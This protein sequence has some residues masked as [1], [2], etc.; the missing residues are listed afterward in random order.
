MQLRKAKPTDQEAIVALLKCSL[1]ETL[2]PKSVKLW[3]WKHVDNPF[4]KSP[5]L[6]AE[7]GGEI[8]GVRAFMPW[9]FAREGQSVKA[10][11]AVDTAIH[12]SF[13]GKGIFKKLTLELLH[14]CMED[15][16]QFIFN[17]PNPQSLPGY[18]KMGWQKRGRLPLRLAVVR[19]LEMFLGKGRSPKQEVALQEWPKDVFNTVS[20]NLAPEGLMTALSDEYL[21]WRYAQNPLFRYGWFSDGESYLCIFRVKA[22]QR[23]SEFR[24]CELLPLGNEM[25]YNIP[26][27][28]KQLKKQVGQYGASLISI[29]GESK[30][31]LQSFGMYRFFKA[32]K[33][34]MVTLRNLGREQQADRKSVV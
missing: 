20:E 12:P 3:Q 7:S 5:V 33:G 27:F 9:R 13:Q 1:G 17:T 26:E 16:F 8:V 10:L 6:V 18:L 24:I 28:N 19:P 25:A 22:H 4:G 30:V 2:L 11:R 32:P 31:P 15:D 14:E 34:P 29:S 21:L 23:F